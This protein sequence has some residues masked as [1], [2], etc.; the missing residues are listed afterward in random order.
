LPSGSFFTSFGA[1]LFWLNI[2]VMF[3][4]TNKG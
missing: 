2:G 1:T 4:A 3:S